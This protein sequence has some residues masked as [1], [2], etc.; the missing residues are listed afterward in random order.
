M[1]SARDVPADVLAHELAAEAASVLGRAGRR[2]ESAVAR[3]EAAADGD[4]KR[5]ALSHLAD[6]VWELGVQREAMG[7]SDPRA[8]IA[9]YRIPPAAFALAGI[10]P[11]SGVPARQGQATRT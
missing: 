11:A 10:M 1:V 4:D 2:V 8:M 9:A 3:Y 7:L 6:A 5:A